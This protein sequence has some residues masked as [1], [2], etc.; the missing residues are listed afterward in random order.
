MRTL[1]LIGQPPRVAPLS[2]RIA[3][4]PDGNCAYNAYAVSLFHYLCRQTTLPRLF[5]TRDRLLL[6]AGAIH[7]LQVIFDRAGELPTLPPDDI[8]TIERTL[9]PTLREVGA[10][11]QVHQFQTHPERADFYLALQF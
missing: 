3:C 4:T 2:Q 11:Y 7:G 6:E 1:G 10:Q 5:F 8:R 9:S